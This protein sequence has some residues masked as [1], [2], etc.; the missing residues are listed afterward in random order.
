MKKVISLALA[1]LLLACVFVGCKSAFDANAGIEQLQ[2]KGLTISEN[3][4]TPEELQGAAAIINANIQSSGAN[5][6]IELK[7]MT[8]MI[9]DEN[10]SRN[11]QILVFE[12][13]AQ[14][15]RMAEYYLSNR[16]EDN[17]YKIARSGNVMI[18][19]SLDIVPQVLGLE[20]E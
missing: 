3:Y 7:Q 20:F 9:Q 11:C 19:T 5:F 8:I 1:I 17:Y 18:A 13:N 15:R 4:D 6:S 14:A 16:T 2:K 10:D 12:T